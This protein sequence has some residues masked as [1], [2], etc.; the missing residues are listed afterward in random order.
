MIDETDEKLVCLFVVLYYRS[1]R[2]KVN[3]AGIE[4]MVIWS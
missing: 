1:A 4:T 2:E 3:D